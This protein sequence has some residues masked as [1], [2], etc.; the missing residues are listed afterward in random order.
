MG[1][2]ASARRFDSPPSVSSSDAISA[3][4]ADDGG[5]TPAWE[6]ERMVKAAPFAIPLAWDTSKSASSIRCHKLIAA[7][8][9]EV[10]RQIVAQGLRGAIKT[11]G[12]CYT[13]RPK[14][15]GV[16]PSTH[17]WGIAIDL[18]PNTNAMGSP[19]DMDP[20]LVALFEGYGFT[21]GGRWAG[22]N[23]GPMHFQYCSGY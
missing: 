12:G 10:F 9:E 5:I 16:K 17:S 19:V 18:N 8:F 20:R 21:C 3:Y 4:Q 1:C 6:A 11:Y 2:I 13:Y 15:N 7:L 23:K 22:S 14:R